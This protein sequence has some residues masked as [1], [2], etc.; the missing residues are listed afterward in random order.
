MGHPHSVWGLL[1]VTGLGLLDSFVYV[2]DRYVYVTSTRW[3][4][5]GLCD[6]SGVLNVGR[7]LMWCIFV[8]LVLLV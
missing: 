5:Q 7:R 2:R 6:S 8:G 4:E 3:V 1:W